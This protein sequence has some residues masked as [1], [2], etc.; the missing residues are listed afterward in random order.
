M[1]RGFNINVKAVTKT[2]VLINPII[3][4]T[5]STLHCDMDFDATISSISFASSGAKIGTKS[6]IPITD[7]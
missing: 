4:L 7:T 2:K 6:I 3:I 1:R 5:P